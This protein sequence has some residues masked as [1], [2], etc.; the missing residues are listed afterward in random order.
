MKETIRSTPSP[1]LPEQVH[2]RSPTVQLA[3]ATSPDHSL[4]RTAAH[5]VGAPLH[6]SPVTTA[7]HQ[8]SLR[9]ETADIALNTTPTNMS[10]P[11]RV[12]KDD[13]APSCLTQP[14]DIPLA[15]SR[16]LLQIPRPR[17]AASSSDVD[18]H[19]KIE[20]EESRL[21]ETV[22]YAQVPQITLP[23]A[24][25]DRVDRAA[26]AAKRAQELQCELQRLTMVLGGLCVSALTSRTATLQGQFL[27]MLWNLCSIL[28]EH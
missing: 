20:K 18:E 8:E 19:S 25:R 10:T 16:H 26:A 21:R 14:P 1:R 7:F 23:T 3:S 27:M 15:S 9:P 13:S 4:L 24:A 28:S 6:S 12:T 17:V 22:V 5:A 2:L 11:L